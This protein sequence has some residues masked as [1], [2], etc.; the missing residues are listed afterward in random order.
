MLIY[1]WLANRYYFLQW[2]RAIVV[3]LKKSNKSNYTQSRAY[4]LITLLECI[5]KL[6]EKVVVY[7]LIYLTG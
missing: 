2:Q 1:W 7:G 4:H 6:L 5:G 3:I